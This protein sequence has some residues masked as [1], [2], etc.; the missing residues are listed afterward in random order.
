VV[1]DSED[2]AK[3]DYRLKKSDTKAD[4]SQSKEYLRFI[5]DTRSMTEHL[6]PGKRHK[7]FA[8]ANN[9]AT[10]EDHWICIRDL[11]RFTGKIISAEPAIGPFALVMT[12]RT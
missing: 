7:L 4:I 6:T 2:K 5:I 3:E 9:I 10:S 12:C 1:A 8:V 11:A